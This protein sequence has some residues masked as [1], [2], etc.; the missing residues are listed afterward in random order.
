M[1]CHGI[2]H[3]LEYVFLHS[4]SGLQSFKIL[5]CA[6]KGLNSSMWVQLSAYVQARKLNGTGTNWPFFV[7]QC[8]L[9]Q[10]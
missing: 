2:F 1:K 7:V 4:V 10:G 5:K 8:K 9:L 3:Q 6:S